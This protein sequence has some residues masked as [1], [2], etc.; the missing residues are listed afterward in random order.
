MISCS[1]FRTGITIEI[2]GDAYMVLEFLHVK[3]GKGAAF[4][5]TKLRNLKTG[6]VVERTFNPNVKF[7][8]ALVERRNM[9]LSYEDGGLYYFMD[10][11]TFEQVPLP[12]SV[13]ADSLKWISE[14]MVCQIMFFNSQAI[15]VEIPNS[16]E[17]VIVEC[18]PGIKGNTAT[19]ATKPAKLS[20]GAIVQVPLFIEEG[21]M[22]RVDTRTGDYLTR[23]K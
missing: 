1:D 8:P 9:T 2:D 13:I 5:R 3:P 4:V 10:Q 11:E 17:L 14:S 15:G 7:P 22:I 20:T 16:V 6:S 12:E 18:E 21:E 19:G 23:V